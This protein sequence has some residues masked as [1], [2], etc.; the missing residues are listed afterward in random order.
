MVEG[1]HSELVMVE[2]IELGESSIETAQ[3]ETNTRGIARGNIFTK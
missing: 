2:V 1:E 3:M